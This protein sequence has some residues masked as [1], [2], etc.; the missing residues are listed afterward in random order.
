MEN[1][2]KHCSFTRKSAWAAGMGR[3]GCFWGV[4]E[5][6]EITP[7]MGG[8]GEGTPHSTEDQGARQGSGKWVLDLE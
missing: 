6:E 7:A 4:L 2:W 1:S 8:R 5:V 3:G